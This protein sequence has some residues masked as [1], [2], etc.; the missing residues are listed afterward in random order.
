MNKKPEN[1][2]VCTNIS[3]LS[4]NERI[5]LQKR[6]KWELRKADFSRNLQKPATLLAN[7]TVPAV[8]KEQK[9]IKK[10][11]KRQMRRKIQKMRIRRKFPQAP[12]PR[13]KFVQY[14]FIVKN[15]TNSRIKFE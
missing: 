2:I 14:G 9:C 12:G 15:V 5:E 11:N 6:L 4:I 10:P 3:S 7:K 1:P 8:R 13:N